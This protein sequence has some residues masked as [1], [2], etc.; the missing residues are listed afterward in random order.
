MM[1]RLWSAISCLIVEPVGA[2]MM[3]SVLA[4]NSATQQLLQDKLCSF[5]YG[6]PDDF[7]KVL[8]ESG[9]SDVKNHVLSDATSYLSSK[10]LISLFPHIILTLFT[11][12]WCDRFPNG[13]RY[14][15]IASL[16]GNVIETGLMLINS[17]CYNWDFRFILFTGIPSALLGNGYI[18]AAYSFMSASIPAEKRAVRFLVLEVFVY[19]GIVLGFLSAGSLI[20]MTSFIFPLSGLRNYADVFFMCLVLQTFAL[21]WTWIRL[22]ETEVSVTSHSNNNEDD[23]K[24]SSEQSEAIVVQVSKRNCLHLIPS[25]FSLT[26]IR[27]TWKTITKKRENNN[28]LIMWLLSGVHFAQMLPIMA[29]AYVIFPLT[30]KIYF[31]N[32]RTYTYYMALFM[33][34]KPFFIALYVTFVVK[35]FNLKPL[36]IVLLGTVSSIVSLTVFGS[37]TNPTGFF[38]DNIV[39]IISFTSTAG[40]RTYISIIIPLNELTKV[41]AITQ[42]AETLLPFMGSA[43]AAGIFHLTIDFYPTLV[44][45]VFAFIQIISLSVVCLMDLSVRKRD[46]ESVSS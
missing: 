8:A 33:A 5:K 12:S 43:M 6:M 37:I 32:F 39:G 34:I 25:L 31:W 46:K 45:H 18:M 42:T 23:D 24:H 19:M 41:F 17:L 14:V 26:H 27:D 40:I 38:I 44:V 2:L 10:E 7:C 36:T 35:R 28:R 9:S 4:R 30:E 21:I 20:N 13:R 16:I 1:N 22:R 29:I 3:A 11:A 15:I